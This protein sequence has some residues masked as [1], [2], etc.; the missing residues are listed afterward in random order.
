MNQGEFSGLS[1]WKKHKLVSKIRSL[2]ISSV[3]TSND[4][5]H[6][7]SLVFTKNFNYGIHLKAVDYA[8][9][10]AIINNLSKS[11]SQIRKKEH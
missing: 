1:R 6:L 10:T 4:I 7:L 9:K 2:I 11:L 5:P 3:T 8:E